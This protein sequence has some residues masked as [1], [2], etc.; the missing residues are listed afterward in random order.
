MGSLFSRHLV[1]ISLFSFSFI[2]I[3]LIISSSGCKDSITDPPEDKPAGYQEDIPWPSLADSPWPMYRCDPQNT[4]R[5]RYNGA[6]SGNMEWSLDTLRTTSGIAVDT[7]S[8][9]YFVCSSVLG[10][11]TGIDGLYAVSPDGTVKWV[12]PFKSY[13]PMSPIIGS[14]GVIYT[15]SDTERRLFAINRNGELIWEIENIFVGCTGNTIGKDGTLY[16]CKGTPDG[17]IYSVSKTGSINWQFNIESM[18]GES[19]ALALSPDSKTLYVIG[20]PDFNLTAINL[21][22]VSIKWKVLSAIDNNPMV[23]FQGNIYVSAHDSLNYLNVYSVT[24]EGNIRWV[25]STEEKDL[26]NFA[27][28]ITIDRLGNLYFCGGDHLY[29][30]DHQGKF[31]WK[32][33]EPGI[34]S[35]PTVIDRNNRIYLFQMV[36]EQPSGWCF[37]NSGN[38]IWNHNYSKGRTLWYSPAVGFNS[39]I[40]PS[41]NSFGLFKLE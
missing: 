2:L 29:S 32:K 40:V 25:F 33:S 6:V 17:R 16:L 35:E 8:T 5:S 12:Y 14:E 27:A 15:A 7:D 13:T 37:D 4:G 10:I 19:S 34:G 22:S 23:D 36:Q 39:I 20:V 31:R 41:W 21:E 3:F 9:I 11:T 18:Y 28:D 30:I 1:L 26:I 24:P 38:L